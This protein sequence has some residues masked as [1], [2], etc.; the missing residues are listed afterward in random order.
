[1]MK[2]VISLGIIAYFIWVFIRHDPK[3]DK[4]KNILIGEQQIILWY[5]SYYGN[6]VHR[7]YLILF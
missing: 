3:I 6:V 2:S 1:M 5:N 7:K 4:V